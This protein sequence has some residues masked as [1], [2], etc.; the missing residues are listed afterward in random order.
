MSKFNNTK[1]N[2]RFVSTGDER[3]L[4][5]MDSDEV[6]RLINEVARVTYEGEFICAA[7]WC[8]ITDSLDISHENEAS[9]YFKE[10][11]E[12]LMG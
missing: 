7:Y 9:L 4:S 11:I 6:K 1:F 2:I 10:N 5:R 12:D 3:T 8:D